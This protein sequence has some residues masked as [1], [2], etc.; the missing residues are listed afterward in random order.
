MVC[1]RFIIR[2]NH[3]IKYMKVPTQLS[4]ILYFWQFSL[5]KLQLSQCFLL[6]MEQLGSE[7]LEAERYRI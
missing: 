6:V 5:K 7:F 4:V 3:C 2:L 1:I